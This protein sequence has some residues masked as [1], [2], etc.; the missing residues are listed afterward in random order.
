M[1]DKFDIIIQKVL[2]S[3][4]G[5][6]NDPHDP[7][8]ETN[9]G[10]SKR[11]FP[12]VDIAKL[13]KADAKSIY[14]KDYW[15]P[16]RAD[17]LPDNIIYIYFD[18]VINMGLSAAVKVLQKAV[19]SKKKG[20]LKVDGR[21]GPNTIKHSKGLE[22]KRLRAYRSLRYAELIMKRPSLER[23]YY[24]WFRRTLEPDPLYDADGPFGKDY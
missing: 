5:Y 8:G 24:G 4:G 23:F 15:K 18:M 3:E 12:D 2:E 16:S 20:R 6:V 11:A 10:I 13:T 9:Y 14:R 19:N 7:G 1:V 22:A 17:E 21:V